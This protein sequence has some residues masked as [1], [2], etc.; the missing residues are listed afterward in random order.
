MG[1]VAGASSERPTCPVI[2]LGWSPGGIS[3]IQL[4]RLLPA[5]VSHS[6]T[7]DKSAFCGAVTAASAGCDGPIR[8]DRRGPLAAAAPATSAAQMLVQVAA[9]AEAQDRHRA[10]LA[11]VAAATSS[12]AAAAA[13][14]GAVRGGMPVGGSGYKGGG[15]DGVA[16]GLHVRAGDRG[17]D[18]AIP[19]VRTSK[20]SDAGSA[21]ARRSGFG[22]SR[23]AAAPAPAPAPVAS[24]GGGRWDSLTATPWLPPP[25]AAG[26][27][28]PVAGAGGPASG[29][30]RAQPRGYASRYAVEAA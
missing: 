25:N 2:S 17:R 29:G 27:P 1:S 26:L 7:S 19:L 28:G 24:R 22:G 10:A 12:T 4:H 6:R 3:H 9:A 11:A 16:L 30:G 5:G 8:P 21:T 23:F 13:A 15:Y 14:A 20:T 18:A